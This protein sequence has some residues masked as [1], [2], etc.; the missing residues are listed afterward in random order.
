[1]RVGNVFSVSTRRES[2]LIAMVITYVGLMDDFKSQ[3]WH[4][5]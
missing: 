2:Y 4:S 5:Y 1:M 3:M